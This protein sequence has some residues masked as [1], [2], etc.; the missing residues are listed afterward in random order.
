[1]GIKTEDFVPLLPGKE[2]TEGVDWLGIL[3]AFD[4]SGLEQKYVDECAR[5]DPC[6]TCYRW[7]TPARP[8][9]ERQQHLLF[10]FERR[11]LEECVRRIQNEGL[12]PV[13][14]RNARAAL[15]K[16]IGEKG[17]IEYN[18]REYDRLGDAG[19]KRQAEEYAAY[20]KALEEKRSR[21]E[22]IYAIAREHPGFVNDLRFDEGY[23][24]DEYGLT[25]A[26]FD[27]LDEMLE[28]EREEARK[29]ANIPYDHVERYDWREGYYSV[30]IIAEKIKAVRKAAGMNQRE[31]A[32]L[33]GYSNVNK[34][35]KFEKGESGSPTYWT[36]IGLIKDVCDA[37]CANP[38]WLER[39]DEETLYNVD[40]EATAETGGYA[41]PWPMYATNR[42]IREWWMALQK[43]RPGS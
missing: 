2:I 41:D 21:R 34:Y 15:I 9:E 16:A 25:D 13:G 26:D 6:N 27:E 24:V 10:G 28:E 38:Y 8:V 40:P 33:I 31:F 5:R 14:Y 19:R 22:K 1:M 42:V 11:R 39:D 12:T 35:A 7:D 29:R 4:P 37:T 18:Q 17:A 3:D 36:K 20:E 43:E 23:Y 32:R 30:P